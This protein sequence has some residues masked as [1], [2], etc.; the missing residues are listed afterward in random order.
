VPN[1]IDEGL[2]SILALGTSQ[3]ILAG[4]G[5]VAGDVFVQTGGTLQPGDSSIGTFTLKGKLA[6]DSG[7]VVDIDINK[8]KS[9][10]DK[11]TITGAVSLRG[12]LQINSTDSFAFGDVFKIIVMTT[13]PATGNFSNFIPA[14]PGNGLAW[15]FNAATGELSV[16]YPLPVK[17]ISFS[18]AYDNKQT[19]LKWTTSNEINLASFN[20]ER[21]IDG[22]NF[23]SIGTVKAIKSA[24][25]NSYSFIDG[26]VSDAIVYYRLKSVDAIGSFEYSKTIAITK[27]I[28]SLFSVYPN[29]VTSTVVV[30]HGIAGA[31]AVCKLY[32]TDGKQVFTQ[33]IKQNATQT[34]I[35]VSR[36]AK[37]SYQLTV[38]NGIEK[39]STIIIKQ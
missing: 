13:S 37:G 18:G 9:T 4:K 14:T 1:C 30:T 24:T 22:R 10:W 39:S 34:S 17:I 35:D 3:G 31:N 6:L 33:A 20:V 28:K 25:A 38:I 15:S 8:A 23:N 11:L 29:P 32:S 21:S 12:T 16:V 5:N 36:L 26:N 19:T 7:S 2:P 27:S